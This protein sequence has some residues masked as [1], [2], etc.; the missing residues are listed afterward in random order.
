M[1]VMNYLKHPLSTFHELVTAIHGM[2]VIM[3]DR[4][5]AVQTVTECY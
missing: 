3:Q 2:F 4:E 1:Q 5:R